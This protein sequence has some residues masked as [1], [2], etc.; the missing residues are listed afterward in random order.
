M[1]MYI[2]RR[3]KEETQYEMMKKTYESL[4]ILHRVAFNFS[5]KR[6]VVTSAKHQRSE[7]KKITAFRLSPP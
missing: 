5:L 2:F 3:D 7:R 6:C 1:E 4:R